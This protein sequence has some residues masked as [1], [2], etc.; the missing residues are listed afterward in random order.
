MK[1]IILAVL[2]AAAFATATA[3]ADEARFPATGENLESTGHLALRASS[4]DSD[5]GTQGATIAWL[6]EGDSLKVL[7]LKQVSTVFGF[8]VWVEVQA[9]NGSKGWINDGM[10]LDVLK[11]RGSL[12]AQPGQVTVLAKAN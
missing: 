1:N 8:E 4:P 5:F 10:A 12:S 11:G 6:K 2:L 9:A 7:S 3:F